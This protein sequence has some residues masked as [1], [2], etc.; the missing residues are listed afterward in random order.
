MTEPINLRS[1]LSAASWAEL[2]Q[3]RDELK[4]YRTRKNRKKG[5]ERI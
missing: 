3:L 1:L 5:A 2:R 4:P